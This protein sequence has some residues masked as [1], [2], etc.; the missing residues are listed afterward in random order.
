MNGFFSMKKNIVM[1]VE[2]KKKKK[3]KGK[4]ILEPIPNYMK[5]KRFFEK[6]NELIL[7]YRLWIAFIIFF[8]I[9]F[10]IY[11]KR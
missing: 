10:E 4:I 7:K 6:I 11:L 2:R 8:I 5:S 9:C 3:T 1:K